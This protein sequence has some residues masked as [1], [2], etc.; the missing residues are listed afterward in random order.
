MQIAIPWRQRAAAPSSSLPASRVG[1]RLYCPIVIRGTLAGKQITLST[2]KYLPP[3][4]ARDLEKARNLALLWEAA[5]KPVRP[6]DHAQQAAPPS[7]EEPAPRGTVADALTSYMSD[8]RDRGNTP[9]TVAK[10]R[11]IFEKYSSAPPLSLQAPGA[12]LTFLVGIRLRAHVLRPFRCG[13]VWTRFKALV[14]DQHASAFRLLAAR[15]SF[16]ALRAV[17]AFLLG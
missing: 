5:G 16:C 17:L 9:A 13:A 12:A 4:E 15:T 10:K 11:T 6:N 7:P 1:P 8:A 2:S 3:D 14:H